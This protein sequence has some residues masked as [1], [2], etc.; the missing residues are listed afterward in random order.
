MPQKY[1]IKF[2]RGDDHVINFVRRDS[3]G[4]IIQSAPTNIY[5]TVKDDDETSTKLLQY[6]Y[7]TDENIYQNDDFSWSIHFS[8]EDTVNMSYDTHYY[9][10]QVVNTENDKSFVTTILNG[11]FT[12]TSEY[13]FEPDSRS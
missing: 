2:T 6:T 3:E 9:D 8:H 5:L 1:N 11:K 4:Q 12:L 7:P 10:I 13:T